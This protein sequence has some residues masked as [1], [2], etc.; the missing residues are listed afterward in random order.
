M[1]F[2]VANGDMLRCASARRVNQSSNL[3]H[4]GRPRQLLNSVHESS[5]SE[6]GYTL[7]YSPLY[8][9]RESHINEICKTGPM[10]S[11]LHP[12]LKGNVKDIETCPNV[13]ESVSNVVA[14][15]DK[16]NSVFDFT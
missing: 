15:R 7:C 10:N 4:L 13:V 16:K 8:S 14:S 11:F 2:V 5:T 1:P 6:L 9:S 3:H 12:T